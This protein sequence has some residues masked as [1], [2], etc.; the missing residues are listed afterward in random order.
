MLLLTLRPSYVGASFSPFSR[1]DLIM[2]TAL[3]NDLMHRPHA[4]NRLK[5][6]ACT[7]LSL[8]LSL[9]LSTHPPTVGLHKSK[10][11]KQFS[12]LP[13]GSNEIFRASGSSVLAEQTESRLIQL[14]HFFHWF[15]TVWSFLKTSSFLK[16]KKTSSSFLKNKKD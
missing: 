6:K 14:D 12:G 13:A 16:R 2:M 4:V 9:S 8:S 1:W 5:V 7:F 15:R 11:T 10:H 3:F